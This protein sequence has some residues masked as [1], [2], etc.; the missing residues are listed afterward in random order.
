MRNVQVIILMALSL[1]ACSAGKQNTQE[2][3]EHVLYMQE[4]REI[5]EGLLESLSEMKDVQVSQLVVEVG[6]SLL[7]TPYVAHTLE[8]KEEQLVINLRELDCTTFAENCLAIARTLKCEEPDFGQFIA[9]L[10]Q[11][12]YRD[13]NLEGYLSRLHYFCDWIHNNQE[14]QVIRDMSA[15][16]S[17]VPLSKQINFMSTHPES[18]QQLKDDQE[19]VE[20]IAGQERG[21]MEREMFYIPEDSLSKV[22]HLLQEGDIVGITTSVEGI[23]IGHVG[24][25][26]RKEGRIH[27]MHA[28]SVAEKV[29][30]SEETLEEY[31]KQRKSS[32]GIMVAR[33]CNMYDIIH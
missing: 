27:L 29:V 33:I 12:R 20:A 23:A 24:I 13:G 28:S 6:S 3:P 16:F 17:G 11:I 25:L 5:L 9:E 18:Y 10:Q 21:I 15:E 2:L 26:V 31:L 4:D 30:V 19:L 14:K 22:E 7:R 1:A 32:T 8:R